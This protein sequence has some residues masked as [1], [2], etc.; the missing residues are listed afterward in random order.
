MKKAKRKNKYCLKSRLLVGSLFILFG[1]YN[2]SCKY[3][4]YFTLNEIDSNKIEEFYENQKN[5]E[6]AI[7]DPISENVESKIFKKQKSN[8]IAV[9]KIPKISLEK[10]LCSKKSSCNNVDQNIQ[11]LPESDYPDSVNGNFILASH[12]GTSRI[13]YFKNLHQLAKDDEITVVY[14]GFEYYY[15]VIRIY[16]IQKTG[17]LNISNTNKTNTLILITCKKG[18]DKQIVVLAENIGK[19]KF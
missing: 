11:I 18:T 1:I 12:S 15:K 10:G 2:I 7:D 6:I 9:I 3:I 5:S 4:V 16:E 17:S 19:E 8:Y 13:S 14:D